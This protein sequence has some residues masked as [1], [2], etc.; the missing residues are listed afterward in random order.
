MKWSKL[1]AIKLSEPESKKGS[2]INADNDDPNYVPAIFGLKLGGDDDTEDSDHVD[3]ADGDS[4][5]DFSR[6]SMDEMKKGAE[7]T[8]ARYRKDLEDE[9]KRRR[10]QEETVLLM[11]TET[12]P[13]LK[14]NLSYDTPGNAVP[15]ALSFLPRTFEFH[16]NPKRLH[17]ELF[18]MNIYD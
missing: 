5:S 2:T 17:D 7:E 18:A 1:E 13:T 6:G 15:Y 14:K 8:A 4:A 11:E 9:E 12:D 16:G 10:E 3:N